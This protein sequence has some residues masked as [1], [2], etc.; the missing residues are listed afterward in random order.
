MDIDLAVALVS[1]VIALIA[2]ALA[3]WGQMKAAHVASQLESLRLAE[4]R[5]FEKETTIARYREPLAQAAYD[6]QSR[7]YN[8]VQRNFLQRYLTNGNDRERAY[9]VNNTVFVLAQYFA[10]TEIVR[11]DIQFIDLGEDRQTRELRRLQD[12]IYAILQNDSWHPL[13]RVFA[14]EQRAVGERLITRARDKADCMG[15]GAFL[16]QLPAGQD[17]LMDALRDDVVETSKNVGLA[18]PRLVA[19]QHA[20]IDLLAFLDPDNVRF[21]EDR[22]SKVAAGA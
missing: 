8:I 14:G 6:L 12:T 22:R 15:Y 20:L 2:A 1:G 17:P 18:T 13:L 3:I 11:S 5:R 9:A 21:S 19:L 4:Q 7:I 16:D 10:W